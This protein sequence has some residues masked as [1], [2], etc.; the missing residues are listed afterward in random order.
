MNTEELAHQHSKRLEA[1]RATEGAQASGASEG[2][3]DHERSGILVHDSNCST[4]RNGE[5]MAAS[6]AI[7]V[8]DLF[9]G[10]GGLGEGF[11]AARPR[12]ESRAGFR[13]R[14]TFRIALSIEKDADAHATLELQSFFRQFAGRRVPEAYY[15]SSTR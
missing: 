2:F 12:S 13:G 4:W 11:S 14:R 3:P 9:A 15:E 6:D 8:I 1:Q 5:G 7:P 10:P